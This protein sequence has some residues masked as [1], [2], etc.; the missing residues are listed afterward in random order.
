MQNLDLLQRSL[1]YNFTNIN[2]LIQALTHK[3]YGKPNY[4]RLEF[5]GDGILDYVIALSLYNNFSDFPEGR[6]SK[7]R[8][9]LVNQ[10]SLCE[11]ASS[12][13]LS[14]YL[15]LGDG[16]EKS[17]GRNRPSILADSLEAIFAAISLDGG[18]EEAKRVILNLYNNK[19]LSSHTAESKDYK[20]LLQ[21][22]LQLH[23]MKLPSY[24]VVEVSGPEHMSNFKVECTIQELEIT[25]Q[26]VGKSKKEASTQAAKLALEI[27]NK[28]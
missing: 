12:F 13:N 20:T 5:L 24:Q 23:K 21:E 19:I 28:S 7:L 16:E 11:I 10:E 26:A 2:L 14:N 3:S 22:Y 6:L 9:T 27:I 25:T 4:E 8:S 17:N 18:F 15:L 1:S